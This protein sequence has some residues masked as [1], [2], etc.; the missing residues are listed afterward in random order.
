MVFGLA[1]PF[2]GA[3]LAVLGPL[4]LCV[5]RPAPW[6]FTDF[7]IPMLLIGNS[8]VSRGSPPEPIGLPIG[9]LPSLI[10]IGEVLAPRFTLVPPLA[11]ALVAQSF[12]A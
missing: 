9:Y 7:S 6:S 3:A 11:R 8:L 5:R 1:P 2:A 4:S 12:G 10:C